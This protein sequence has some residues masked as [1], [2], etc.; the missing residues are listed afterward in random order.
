MAG[1]A[2]EV[3]VGGVDWFGLSPSGAGSVTGS[4]TGTGIGAGSMSDLEIGGATSATAASETTT[5][6]KRRPG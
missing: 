2:C 3:A 4:G 1:A 6:G 5:I